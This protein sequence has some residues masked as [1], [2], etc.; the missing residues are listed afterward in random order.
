MPDTIVQVINRHQWQV[1]HPH[2]Q[3][4]AQGSLKSSFNRKD[5]TQ[6]IFCKVIK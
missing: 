2:R 5:I 1:V 6:K 4:R 3:G